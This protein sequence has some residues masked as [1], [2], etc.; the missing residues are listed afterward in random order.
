MSSALACGCRRADNFRQGTISNG[1]S[2]SARTSQLLVMLVLPMALQTV[3]GGFREGSAVSVWAVLSPFGAL[4]FSG[5][6]SAKRWLAAYLLLLSVTALY[7]SA[8]RSSNNLPG[9]LVDA[10]FLLNIAALSLITFVILA[11]FVSRLR[12]ERERSES[13]LLNILPPSIAARLPA[14]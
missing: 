11:T 4:V 6:A 2:S 13:L 1:Y 3:L 10:F 14:R 9:W 5:V 8:L 7:G 12:R